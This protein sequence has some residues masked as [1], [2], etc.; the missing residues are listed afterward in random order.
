MSVREEGEGKL[1]G[2]KMPAA[3][4][5]YSR[6]QM[7]EPNLSAVVEVPNRPL[8]SKSRISIIAFAVGILNL[9]GC[10][11]QNKQLM[12]HGEKV[13][14]IGRHP[15]ILARVTD[16]LK[17]HH[18]DAIGAMT[19][20][21]ALQKFS[22]EK[23]LAVIIGGGVDSESRALFHRAFSASA[24]VIDAHPQTILEDLKEAFPEK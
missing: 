16:M 5:Q 4:G 14:I 1:R 18:Y 24:K 6:F 8:M 21:E 2:D 15:D 9:F 17:N 19:N 12:G 10:E 20:E 23:P 22:D 3:A 7:T 13:L 11:A